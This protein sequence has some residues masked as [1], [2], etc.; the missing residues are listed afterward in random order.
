MGFRVYNYVVKYII[1]VLGF[2]FGQL[3]T[4]SGQV[5]LYHYF[6]H[7]RCVDTLLISY[8]CDSNKKFSIIRYFRIRLDS[9]NYQFKIM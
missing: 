7:H 3:R 2:L 4:V 6:C 1:Q 9:R 8:F 5:Y